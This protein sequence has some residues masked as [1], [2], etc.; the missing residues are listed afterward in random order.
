MNDLITHW[1]PAY[2]GLG[3]NMDKPIQQLDLAI[4]TLS[5]HPK[6][7][8]L[9]LSS[10]YRSAPHGP[11]EQDDFVNA[12]AAL[13]TTLDAEELLHTMQSIENSQERK[14]IQH[15]GPRTLDLDLLVYSDQTLDN[16][17]LVLPHPEISK[18]EFVLLPFAEIASEVHVPAKGRISEL[19]R[20]VERSVIHKLDKA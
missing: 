14:R 18:R 3:S 20:I 2:I 1:Y 16:E 9:E 10:Y 12:V 5:E 15:W 6:I 11:V 13:L 19:Y 4:A 7:K 8:V 17:F